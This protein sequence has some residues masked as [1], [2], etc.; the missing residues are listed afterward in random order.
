MCIRNMTSTKE[1]SLYKLHFEKSTLKSSSCLVNTNTLCWVTRRI[2]AVFLPINIWFIF[3]ALAHMNYTLHVMSP[4][5][6]IKIVQVPMTPSV[7]TTDVLSSVAPTRY[8]QNS[9]TTKEWRRK[10]PSSLHLWIRCK[11]MMGIVPWRL[12]MSGW[13]NCNYKDF[14]NGTRQHT[15]CSALN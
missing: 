8:L 15:I 10:C 7:K 5:S 2:S 3:T 9:L 6:V 13:K 11:R 4:A 12:P 1:I 14:S